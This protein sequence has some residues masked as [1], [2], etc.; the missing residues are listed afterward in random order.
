MFPH[1]ETRNEHRDRYNYETIRGQEKAGGSSKEELG[2]NPQA[3]RAARVLRAKEEVGRG[4]RSRKTGAG[5][6]GGKPE[7]ARIQDLQ[8]QHQGAKEGIASD[9]ASERREAGRRGGHGT[10]TK[11]E[12]LPL[13]CLLTLEGKGLAQG[14]AVD[15]RWSSVRRAEVSAVASHGMLMGL[16]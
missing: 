5:N 12:N 2:Y 16:G 10:R 8:S 7:C 1:Q 4:S 3:E 15:K 9:G 13:L 6:A 14:H 11:I